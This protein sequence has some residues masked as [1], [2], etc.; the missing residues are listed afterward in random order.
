VIY[1]D[2]VAGPVT[3][4]RFYARDNIP[5]VVPFTGDVSYDHTIPLPGGSTLTL[6]GDARWHTAYDFG[7]ITTL[8]LN[9]PGGTTPSYYPFIRTESGWISD[10]NLSWASVGGKFSVTGY[11]RNV[12]NSRFK[13]PG[14][15]LAG[16]PPGPVTSTVTLSD[17]RTVGVVLSARF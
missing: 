5:G 14:P 6:H 16:E 2:P 15:G 1:T 13:T 9:P 3:F 7:S 8:Q 17:P 10:L 11:V 4:G 12:G